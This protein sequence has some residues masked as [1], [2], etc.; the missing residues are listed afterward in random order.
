MRTAG[1][2]QS[3]EEIVR[4]AIGKLGDHLLGREMPA[5]HFTTAPRLGDWKR[6]TRERRSA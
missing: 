3:D 5:H 1:L 2:F 4:C 6:P